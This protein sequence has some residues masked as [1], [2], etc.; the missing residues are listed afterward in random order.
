VQQCKGNNGLHFFVCC[1]FTRAIKHLIRLQCNSAEISE[2]TSNME[3]GTLTALYKRGSVE[4]GAVRRDLH[5][6]T[7]ARVGLVT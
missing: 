6:C 5:C 2:E 3:E 1:L 4:M 7:G